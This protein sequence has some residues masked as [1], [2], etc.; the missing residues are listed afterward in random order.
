MWELDRIED[1]PTY[2][3]GVVDVA[4]WDIAGKPPVLPVH[5]LIGRS[6]TR[7]P[8]T[9]RPSP[10]ASIEEYLDVADQCLELGYP[11]HQT[12]RLGRRPRGRRL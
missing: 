10:S 6:A 5:E 11:R 7:S 8:R 12:A 2:V 1:F 4:L 9:P 3:N